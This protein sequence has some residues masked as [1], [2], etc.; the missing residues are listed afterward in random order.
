VLNKEK[1][2]FL[3]LLFIIYSGGVSWAHQIL[4]VFSTQK[5]NQIF[6]ENGVPAY[7]TPEQAVATYMYMY[8]YKT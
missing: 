7:S 2:Y 6:T 5:A 3:G 4:T 1:I 8:Q